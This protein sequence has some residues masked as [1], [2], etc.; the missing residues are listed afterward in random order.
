VPKTPGPGERV[1]WR[2]RHPPAR[3]V[4]LHLRLAAN[5]FLPSRFLDYRASRQKGV[6]F[7]SRMLI[8]VFSTRC[9]KYGAMGAEHEGHMEAREKRL[10]YAEDVWGFFHSSTESEYR[11]G[12]D[13]V[14][15]YEKQLARHGRLNL[16]PTKYDPLTNITWPGISG[17]RRVSSSSPARCVFSRRGRP[18]Y[19][20]RGPCWWC[21][22]PLR[23]GQVLPVHRPEG[24]RGNLK[25]LLGHGQNLLL[26]P[27]I[28]VEGSHDSSADHRADA[29]YYITVISRLTT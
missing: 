17:Q 9:S 8:R 13:L 11:K 22:I 6:F 24:R 14:R 4:W 20:A 27:P 28:V 3:T 10:V 1:I 5:D 25:G 15:E 2:G 12:I 29:R 16:A 26:R 23:P 19:Y 7:S 21:A 18:N